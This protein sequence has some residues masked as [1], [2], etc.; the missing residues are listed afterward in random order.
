MTNGLVFY[1]DMSNTKKSFKGKP[2]TNLALDTNYSSRTYYTAYPAS[3]WGGDSAEVY[4]YP[5]GGYDGLPYKRMLKTAAGT[6]G[7]YLD[8][9][10]SFTL[11]EGTTYTVSC[12]MRANTNVT[13]S[14]HTLALNRWADN[15]YRVPADINLTP[16]W[17]RQSW[18]YTCGVGEGGTTY[19]LRQIVYNDDL[20]PLEIFWCGLQVE[21]GSFATPFVNGTRSNTQALLD[22]TGNTTTD[23]TNV[24]YDSVGKPEFATAGK[25]ITTSYVPT[26]PISTLEAM[27]YP[28]ALGTY[29]CIIQTSDA[30]DAAFYLAPTGYLFWY[31]YGSAGSLI[32]PLNQWSYVAAVWNGNN[33]FFQLNGTYIQGGGAT[34]P[35]YTFARIGAGAVN[36]SEGFIGKI[37]VVR[38]Y[39]R[40]LTQ[41]ELKQNFNALRGRFGI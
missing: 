7:S 18:L 8:G 13:V 32:P 37:D 26:S 6:G 33:Y 27:I 1:Y 2:V 24:G 5:S 20:L 28:T 34:A 11:V 22:L 10:Y 30:N 38:I 14:G 12:Y 19:G 31:P 4:F 41:V 23:V 15:G 40:A 17:T 39:N 16:T 36:D 35:T 25:I 29:K 9:H 21:E 3:S